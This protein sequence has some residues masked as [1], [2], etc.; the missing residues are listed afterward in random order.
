MF[1][2]K[3]RLSA[4]LA[5][6]DIQLNKHFGRV[7]SLTEELLPS[8]AISPLLFLSWKITVSWIDTNH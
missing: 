7:F 2:E 4:H 3:I 1:T 8:Q 5:A 6:S